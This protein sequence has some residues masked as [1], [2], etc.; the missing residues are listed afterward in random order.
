MKHIK[1]TNLANSL[2]DSRDFV[3]TVPVDLVDL[4]RDSAI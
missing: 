4:E 3:E 2:L 1:F